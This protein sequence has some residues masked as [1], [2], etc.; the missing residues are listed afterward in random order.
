MEG[1][2]EEQT[3]GAPL[4]LQ[5]QQQLTPDKAKEKDEQEEL[6]LQQANGHRHHKSAETS[7]QEKGK[8]RDD[9]EKEEASMS[10]AQPKTKANNVGESSKSSTEAREHPMS[11]VAEYVQACGGTRVIEKVLIAN[12]GIAAVKEMRS[13]RRWAYQN[14]GDEGAVQ[15]VVMATPEDIKANAEYIRMA[16]EFEEVP[17]GSNINNYANV[18]LIVDIAERRGVQAVWAGWGH[19][20]ENPRLPEALSRTKSKIA[21][22]GPPAKAMRDLGDKVCSTILAQS[23]NVSV[24]PWSGEG[25]TVDYAKDGITDE[26]VLRATVRSAQ[27]ALK[28]LERIG[29]P[30][31]I[32]ASEGGGGKGIRKVLKEEEVAAAF[33]QVSSEVPNS[34]I[35]IMKMVQNCHHLEVQVL[36]DQYGQAISLYGRDCSVQRRHQKIIEE[37]PVIVASPDVWVEMEQAAV[38]LAMMVGYVSAG[39]I[40]YLYADG[41]YYFLELNPRLQVEH[42]V[43][44]QITNINLPAAQLNV[45]MGIPLHRIPEIRE[46]YGEEPF[47]TS[48]FPLNSPSKPQKPPVGHVIACRITAE[49]PDA[50]FKPTSGEINTLDFKS[51]PN[52]WGYFSVDSTG[53]LHEFADSQFGHLF[54]WGKNRSEARQ[55]MVLALKEL[56]IRGE[57]RTPVEV[58]VH[59]MET[60]AFKTME[61]STSWLDTLIAQEVVTQKPDTFLVVLCG[62]VYNGFTQFLAM[63]EQF[64][65][66]LKRGQIPGHEF[67]RTSF[68]VELIY[69]QTKYNFIVRMT[70]PRNFLISLEGSDATGVEAEVRYLRGEGLLVLLDGK[71]HV[72][73]GKEEVTGLRLTIGQRTV[74]FTKEHDPSTLRTATPCKLVRY[75]VDDGGHVKAGHAYAEVEVMKMYMPLIAK[76]SGTI[77]FIKPEGSFLNAGDVLATMVLDDPSSVRTATRF[78]GQ[79]PELK[80][81]RTTESKVHQLLRSTLNAL[82][83]ILQ[84]YDNTTMVDTVNNLFNYLYDPR[85]PLQEFQEAISVVPSFPA[86]PEILHSLLAKI[87]KGLKAYEASLFD[88]HSLDE[89]ISPTPIKR[90]GQ[91]AALMMEFPATHLLSI[92]KHHLE[93]NRSKLSAADFA[94]FQKTIQPLVDLAQGYE[95]GLDGNAVRRISSLLEEYLKVENLF[96]ARHAPRVLL[97]LRD[98]H[99]NDLL[100]TFEIALSHYKAESKSAMLRY[101][102]RCVA[103]VQW[104]C[105]KDYIGLLHDLA[106]LNG[107]GNV[108]VSLKARQLL[109]RYQLPSFSQRKVTIEDYLRTTLEQNPA[110]RMQ[111]ISKLVDQSSSMFDVLVT[112]FSHS[113]LDIQKV[114]LEVYIRRTY[115]TYNIPS[116]TVGK[117]ATNG[118]LWGEWLFTLPDIHFHT[119][120]L[121]E[122]EK[123]KRLASH[124]S[125]DDLYLLSKQL[126]Q[127]QQ[128][129]KPDEDDE[130]GDSGYQRYGMMLVFEDFEQMASLFEDCLASYQPPERDEANAHTEYLNVLNVA[131][132]QSPE[133][134]GGDYVV[135]PDGELSR[136]PSPNASARVVAQ[137]SDF[138]KDR[139]TLLKRLGIR[140][141]TLVITRMEQFPEFYTF[142][143]RLSFSEDSIFRHIE[144][145]LAYHLEL[146]RLSNYNIELVP[147]ANRQLHL[148]YAE[149]KGR[150]RQLDRDRCFFVRAVIREGNV[151][152]SPSSIH[153][154]D[155]LHAEGERVFG[156]AL[157]ALELAMGDARFQNCQNHHIFLKFVPEVVFEPEKVNTIIRTLA[158]RYG[159]R[160]WK[161]KVRELEVMGMLKQGDTSI[162]IRFFASNPSGYNFQVDSYIEVKEQGEQGRTKVTLTSIDPRRVGP[163]QGHDVREPYPVLDSIQRKRFNARKSNTTYAYDFIEV[164][165]AALKQSWKKYRNNIIRARQEREQNPNLGDPKDIKEVPMPREILKAFELVPDSQAENGLKEVQR[166]IG[167]N[168]IGM[169]AWRLELFT[170]ECPKGRQVIVIANDITFQI[171]SFGPAEDHFFKKASQ[172]ARKLGL[173]RIYLACNSGARI[174]LAQEIKDT[175][176]LAWVDENDPAKGFRYLYLDETTYQKHQTSVNADK[177]D[178][179]IWKIKD[180]IGAEDGLGVENLRGSGMIAGETSRAYD[181]IFTITL[182]TGRTVGIGAYLIR[183]GQR[184]VQNQGPIL[185]TGAPALNK[186]L[187]REVYTSNVQLGGPQIMFANGVSH[188]AVNDELKGVAAILDWLS[189][190]PPQKG[191]PLPILQTY[192]P[193]DRDVA[194]MPQEN[195]PYDPRHMIAGYIVEGGQIK[196]NGDKD[197]YDKLDADDLSFLTAPTSGGEEE[198]TGTWISGFFDRDSWQETLAGWAKTVVCGRA[199]LGGIPIGVIATETRVMERVTPA[200]PANLDS[201]ES[202]VQQAGGVWFP[203]SAYKTA[204]AIKDFNKGEELPLLIF[205]NWRGFSG[206]M[207]DMFD[208]ILKFGSYIVDHLRDYK[209]PVFIYLPPFAEL[210][211]GAWVVLDPTINPHMMEMYAAENSRGGVLEPSGTVEIKFRDRDLKKAMHRLDPVLIQLSTS[212]KHISTAAASSSNSEPEK[213]KEK[214][215]PHSD[216]DDDETV[217]PAVAK[218]QQILAKIAQREDALMPIYRQAAVEFAALHDT[219][220]R[221]KAKGCIHDIVPWRRSREF[222]YYRL[223][224]RLAEEQLRKR[225]AEANDGAW[226]YSQTT[227]V[228][229]KWF[230]H[231]SR[232]QQAAASKEEAEKE[233]GGTDGDSAWKDDKLVV[234]W[235]EGDKQQIEEQIKKVRQD[236]IKWKGAKLA[237][238]D[239]DAWLLMITETLS[240]LDPT[241]KQKV[242]RSV[243]RAAKGSK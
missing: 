144:P 93:T 178:K 157:N 51:K 111:R 91:T 56:S 215:K 2:A 40:E 35:F 60:E 225:I 61:I 136:Y 27:E 126:E 121:S 185:L 148:Y 67:L 182:V 65:S 115:C 168:D 4:S 237:Q 70:G 228:L 119:S 124:E 39:T 75:L 238:E 42:P 218:R 122:S 187:G 7:Q 133:E 152:V 98:Q 20:S 127:E 166:P 104:S 208:E 169:V 211:G 196:G 151:F 6:Q 221:M 1:T 140:R 52:V 81:P 162:P 202:V 200:D 194:F 57:I 49:N 34:P 31:M 207:R 236:T 214:G 110:E 193:V 85:L 21:F 19:A 44:E 62:A 219:P 17:G 112:F 203:D 87:D 58:L 117:N 129:P 101:L 190:I 226:T 73:Y 230:L 41:K 37:G 179:D 222:F 239:M 96:Q 76:E 213:Q 165:R 100:K 234:E 130:E 137:F 74:M 125:V 167:K 143:E 45:A 205:A 232:Q 164:F 227:Q 9:K 210:R 92:I 88:I 3:L 105:M 5:Q 106:A 113:N 195:M 216:S 116:L 177:V 150:E 134:N 235:L 24:V 131:L 33:R 120:S 12:N 14:F 32:K 38:R 197:S 189:Y 55:I 173:P 13:V 25:I 64:I 155:L 8:E 118:V 209:Q 172:Y 48:E 63:R 217:R 135:G 192:D 175:F 212:L 224:R 204:Q 159:R 50:G 53:S 142:R 201:E 54:A 43:T 29:Y 89:P 86:A 15:F 156:E 191:A 102:L 199:R 153:M 94:N 80:K 66:Y 170:P 147:T 154:H 163:L 22:L 114:G 145:P 231:S 103:H 90:G 176:K 146:N 229:Q 30:A 186:V 10:A 84:G 71:S 132:I 183:L 46:F 160:L 18:D 233:Q 174:G 181:E 83:L 28:A 240:T 79:L 107:Q 59:L 69:N 123:K 198:N 184:T 26:V 95:A 171:G 242:L 223:R 149:E 78:S 138:L 158:D 72:V 206:G 161:L 97:E 82:L 109:I 108:E 243:Q 188:V 68:P 99:K 11:S 23:A 141:V 77:R 139:S 241:Q 36:A 220:G 47:G 128:Q 16:D 180:I